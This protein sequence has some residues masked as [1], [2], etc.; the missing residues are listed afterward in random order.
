MDGEAGTGLIGS[1][2]G[3]VVFLVLLSFA[4]QVLLTLS[5]TTAMSSA[6]YEA[7]RVVARGGTTDRGEERARALLGRFAERVR[8]DWSASAPDTVVLRVQADAPRLAPALTPARV[9]RID[10][11]V[12][13][14]VERWR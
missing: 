13:I 7:A 14:H 6:A 8:F 10:R 9:G 3:L 2:A 1:F 12:R 4:T 11:T 5:A